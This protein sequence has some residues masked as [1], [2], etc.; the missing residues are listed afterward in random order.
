MGGIGLKICGL[1]PSTPELLPLQH[2]TGVWAHVL[3][4]LAAAPI[5]PFVSPP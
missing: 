2:P 4:F 1:L 3:G 5:S